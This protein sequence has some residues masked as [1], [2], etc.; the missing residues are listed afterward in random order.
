MSGLSSLIAAAGRWKGSYRL[1]EPSASPQQS[2]AAAL[3]VPIISD[4]FIRIEYT[5]SYDGAPQE[6]LLLVGWENKARLVTAVWIDSWHMGDKFMI[7][8]GA[9]KKNGAVAV[10]GSYAIHSSPDWGWRSVIESRAGRSLRMLMYNI[11]PDGKEDLAVEASFTKPRTANTP[12]NKRLQ[13]TKAR[14]EP[15]RRR[16]AATRLRG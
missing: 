15:A 3:I 2:S 1:W 4:R 10:R 13:P 7:C 11:S 5:W 16:G 14:R 9:V 6:G 8:Q 12:P